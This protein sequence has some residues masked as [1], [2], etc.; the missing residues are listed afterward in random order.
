M[1]AYAPAGWSSASRPDAPMARPTRPRRERVTARLVPAIG[2]ALVGVVLLA[3]LVAAQPVT[4]PVVHL[5]GSE[6]GASLQPAASPNPLRV[7]AATPAAPAPAAA[8]DSAPAAP[9]TAGPPTLDPLDVTVKAV[10]VL[11]LLVVTLFVLRR[12]GTGPRDPRA[13]IAV[14]E[15]RSIAHK[16]QVVLVAVGERRLVVGV[17]AGSMT[18]LADIDPADLEPATPAPLVLAGRST[19]PVHPQGFQSALRRA[20]AAAGLPGVSVVG[21]SR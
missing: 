18:T 19:D 6:A 11:G 7:A 12:I 5:T 16:A 13:R 14:L 8:A 4:S 15:S 20:A 1:T 3:R 9:V 17:T 21:G 2:F 10:F